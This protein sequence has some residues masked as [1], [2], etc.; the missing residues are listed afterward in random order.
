MT[1]SYSSLRGNHSAQT[2][3]PVQT[4]P[5]RIPQHVRNMNFSARKSTYTH[6]ECLW[7]HTHT[8]THT[9][10]PPPRQRNV[11]MTREYTAYSETPLPPPPS[12]LHH[13]FRRVW[14]TQDILNAPMGDAQS[15]IALGAARWCTDGS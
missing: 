10:I 8:H 15:W 12:K 2:T 11:N 13:A 5:R 7:Q 6:T 1:A 4:S 9:S 3:A 14:T